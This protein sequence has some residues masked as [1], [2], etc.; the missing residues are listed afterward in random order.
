MRGV[1]AEAVIERIDT[2]LASENG[3]AAAL[4]KLRRGQVGAGCLG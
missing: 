4:L 1:S 3:R 2:T